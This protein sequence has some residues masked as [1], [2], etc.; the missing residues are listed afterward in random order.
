MEK[1]AVKEN[2]Y[3]IL[4]HARRAVFL[5]PGTGFYFPLKSATPTW[6]LVFGSVPLRE[7]QAP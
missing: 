2:V 6:T 1:G 3:P 5:P 7:A 4:K